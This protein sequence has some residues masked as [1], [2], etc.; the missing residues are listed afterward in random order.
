LIVR[1]FKKKGDKQAALEALYQSATAMDKA[2]A[3]ALF[4]AQV[5]YGWI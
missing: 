2:R 3:L 4:H 1:R 5:N